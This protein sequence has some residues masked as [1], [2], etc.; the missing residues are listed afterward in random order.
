M[1]AELTARP[2]RSRHEPHSLADNQIEPALT[3]FSNTYPRSL[4][5]LDDRHCHAVTIRCFANG[6]DRTRM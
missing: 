2:E 1:C 4:Q 6:L 3:D 5:V